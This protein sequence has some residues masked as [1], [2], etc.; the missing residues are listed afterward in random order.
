MKMED[1]FHSQFIFKISDKGHKNDNSLK[2]VLIQ[3]YMKPD[4][5]SILWYKTR[6]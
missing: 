3:K 4:V 1:L 2:N 6:G 5:C